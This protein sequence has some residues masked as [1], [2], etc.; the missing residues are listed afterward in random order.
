MESFV[1]RTFFSEVLYFDFFR[2][3]LNLSCIYENVTEHTVSTDS[4]LGSRMSLLN[5]EWCSA[6]GAQVAAYHF[7]QI[8]N[9]ETCFLPEFLRNLIAQLAA[10]PSLKPYAEFLA[11]LENLPGLLSDAEI[12]KDSIGIFRRYIVEPLSTIRRQSGQNL[13]ILIDGLCEAEFHRPEFGDSIGSFVVK[14]F[15]ELPAFLRLVFTVKT[16]YLDLV[17]GFPCHKISLENLVMDERLFHD[18]RDY[19]TT[20][21]QM[22]PN[23]QT[24]ISAVSGASKEIDAIGEFVD[25][26]V[27]LCKGN[28]LYLRLTLNLIEQGQLVLKSVNFKI[29]PVSLSEVF[30]LLFN[31]RFPS[32][33]AFEAAAPILN[34]V[35]A[36]LYPLTSR[37]IYEAYCAGIT[38]GSPTWEAFCEKFLLVTEFMVQ[39]QDDTYVLFHPAFREWLIRRE[40]G[41]SPKFLCDLR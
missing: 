23:L 8:D 30:L 35:L 33:T 12:L 9:S 4:G 20:R 15:R 10:T 26:S 18:C 36:S 19:V 3:P 2:N 25:H 37:E 38:D 28:I 11:K 1:H 27:S 41:E 34:I 31:M 16:P 24:Q 32:A 7:C 14:N 40:D 13:L 39:R 29:V 6:V 21:I 17:R 5:Q 22:S